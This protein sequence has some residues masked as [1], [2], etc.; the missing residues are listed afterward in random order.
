MLS[1]P[2]RL[3]A[4][5]VFAGIVGLAFTGGF[6]WMGFAAL[7]DS[8]GRAGAVNKELVKD[9][10]PDTPALLMVQT[11][12]SDNAL[13]GVTVMVETPKSGGWIIDLPVDTLLPAG[14]IESGRLVDVFKKSGK[15]GLKEAVEGLLRVTLD[16]D[17]VAVLSR[18]DLTGVVARW[19][20]ATIRLARPIQDR[21][22]HE[23]YPVGLQDRGAS[24]LSFLL[25]QRPA[26]QSPLEIQDLRLEIFRAILGDK[27]LAAPAAAPSGSAK[28]TTASSSSTTTAVTTPN[29]AVPGHDV[30]LAAG[31]LTWIRSGK[32]SLADLCRDGESPCKPAKDGSITLFDP[33]LRLIVAESMPGRVNDLGQGVKL[34]VISHQG[35]DSE[36]VLLH[37]AEKGTSFAAGV[38][39]SAT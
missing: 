35:E 9:Q 4:I 13:S 19:A 11:G 36:A 39:V 29:T 30:A 26:E 27:D 25:T 31:F 15:A 8:K 23:L 38:L 16:D 37:A 6:A 18:A 1:S 34:R 3:T 28:A 32:H 5:G 2:R 7:R 24:E 14:G 33:R 10:F 17:G 20:P 12:D 21:L 22:G